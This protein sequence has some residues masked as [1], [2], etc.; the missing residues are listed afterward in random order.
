MMYA[1]TLDCASACQVHPDSAEAAAPV[2]DTDGNAT[3]TVILAKEHLRG[4][5]MSTLNNQRGKK[6]T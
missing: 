5:D 6:N 3:K 2:L 4:K 1:Y